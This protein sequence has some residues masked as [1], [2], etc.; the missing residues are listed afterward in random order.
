[1]DRSTLIR[2]LLVGLFIGHAALLAGL[3]RETGLE[4]PRD[5]MLVVLAAL[6][7]A[8]IAGI[9]SRSRMGWFL[10]LVFVA[11]AVGRYAFTLGLETTSGFVVLVG[12]ATAVL[13][14][15]DPGL[16]REHGIAT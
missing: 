14:I 6:N 8:G 12:I 11:A 15:T 13:C 4:F 7:C 3:L 10:A 16:R 5:W 2:R 9:A 1:M